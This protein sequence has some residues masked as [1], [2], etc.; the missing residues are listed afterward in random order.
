MWSVTTRPPTIAFWRWYV[1]FGSK[2]VADPAI[3]GDASSAARATGRRP[4]FNTPH[5]PN[6][7]CQTMT[8]GEPGPVPAA[9]LVPD[10]DFAVE[11]VALDGDLP[12][13]ADRPHEVV[14]ARPV[15][16]PG[17]RDDVLLD[18]HGA[19]VVGA[20]P[21]RDLADLHPLRDPA[22]L[23]VVDVVEVDAADRLRQ[24]VVERGREVAH[25]V[26]QARAV[27]LERPGDEGAEAARLVLELPDPAH[28]LHALLE[29]LDVAVHHRRR[30]GDAEAVSLAHDAEPIRRLGLLRRDDVAD[31]VDEDFRA[32]A[33]DRVE[34]GVA[35][36]RQ[37][38]GDGEL[39]PARDVL[40]L[41]RRQH[42]QVD[43][44]AL[45]DR[46]EEVF[47]ELDAEIGV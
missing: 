10:L 17:G 5:A 44:V 38:L 16:R 3:D 29:R 32:S 20:E 31:A 26:G 9:R 25:L 4:L 39:R 14:R 2:A 45:L 11:R 47:V 34:P 37:C 24:Q 12:G 35:Q 41:G 1:T 42:V 15:R 36:P 19:H 40:D 21:E 30:G 7:T 46:P 23:D 27:G 18:H 8:S 6:H 22:R 28:V 43:A 33:R 13:G